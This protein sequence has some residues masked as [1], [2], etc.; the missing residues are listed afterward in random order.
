MGGRVV[1]LNLDNVFKYTGFFWR[2]PLRHHAP[3]HQTPEVSSKFD[4]GKNLIAIYRGQPSYIMA[5][6]FLWLDFC[7]TSIPPPTPQLPGTW[8]LGHQAWKL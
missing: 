6:D 2:L 1:N 5:P 4:G 3:T 8:L 7:S